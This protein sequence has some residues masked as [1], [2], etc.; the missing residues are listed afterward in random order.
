[1]MSLT[2]G[3]TVSPIVDKITFPQGLTMEYS[4]LQSKAE[5][6]VLFKGEM[7]VMGLP[8][9]GELSLNLNQNSASLQVDMP[10]FKI[11]GGNMQFIG[12]M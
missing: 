5:A 4:L 11:G 2:Y 6:P 8:S 9:Y 3:D 12:N 7:K 1:M 10:P